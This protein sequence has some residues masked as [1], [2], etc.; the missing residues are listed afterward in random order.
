MIKKAITLVFDSTTAPER[1]SL[2]SIELLRNKLFYAYLS[3]VMVS[4]WLCLQ[5]GSDSS[6]VPAGSEFTSDQ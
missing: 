5:T 4:D 2:R 1:S 3:Y 6:L